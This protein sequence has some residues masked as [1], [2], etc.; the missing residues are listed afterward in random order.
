[1]SSMIK[2]KNVGLKRVNYNSPNNQQ[3]NQL[4]VQSN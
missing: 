3:Q 4:I 2:K 1:M